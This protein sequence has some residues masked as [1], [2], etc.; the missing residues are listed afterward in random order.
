M[1]FTRVCIRRT[2]ALTSLAALFLA[3]YLTKGFARTQLVTQAEAQL[4]PPPNN[5][6]SRR[7]VTRGPAIRVISPDAGLA[8][9]KANE[10]FRLLVEFVAR[11]SSR[12]D[13]ASMRAAYLR[14][15]NIDL[16]GRLRTFTSTSG[17][18]LG[19]S[20]LPP[21]D[22]TLRLEVSDDQG[23]VSPTLLVIRE[24]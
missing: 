14:A 12:I 15:N 6:L 2:W 9:I 11:G 8:A 17:I 21:G 18:N 3:F 22:H 20:A 16:T 13:Q 4:L 1:P 24:C 23:R 7:A 5:D 10:P 19:E